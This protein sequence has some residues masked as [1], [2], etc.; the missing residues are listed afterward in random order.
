MTRAAT[1]QCANDW[2]ILTIIVGHLSPRHGR[3]EY[4]RLLER[5]NLQQDGMSSYEMRTV[6]RKCGIECDVT[7]IKGGDPLQWAADKLKE[8]HTPVLRMKDPEE[9]HGPYW[10]L[11]RPLLAGGI[12]L[13][14][15]GTSEGMVER[16]HRPNPALESVAILLEADLGVSGED[17]VSLLELDT[18][19]T[20]WQEHIAMA[21]W[22]VLTLAL[23][24]CGKGDALRAVQDTVREGRTPLRPLEAIELNGMLQRGGLRVSQLQ[25]DPGVV[26]DAAEQEL[27]KG[28][29]PVVQVA[30]PHDSRVRIWAL[31]L[32][33]GSGSSGLLVPNLTG[34]LHDRLFSDAPSYTGTMLLIHS[35]AQMTAEE[36]IETFHY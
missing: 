23:G 25:I 12:G 19:D 20:R 11:A 30:D 3:K 9:G 15:L 16:L 24:V 18:L 22:S 29:T 13:V 28:R 14:A 4:E 34:D 26:E 27:E 32:Y 17:C 8:G 31:I 6:L 7:C 21:D 5:A 35:R 2:G 10:V 1:P 36:V 33:D